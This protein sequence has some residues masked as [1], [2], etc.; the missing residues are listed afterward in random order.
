MAKKRKHEQE[1]D[2]AGE[3]EPEPQKKGKKKKLKE[4]QQE[5]ETLAEI[6]APE[7]PVKKKK[8]SK[9]KLLQEQDVVSCDAGIVKK[10]KKTKEQ[11]VDGDVQQ[12][13]EKKKKRKQSLD[14]QDADQ[15]ETALADDDGAAPDSVQS[16]NDHKVFVGGLPWSVDEATLAEDFKECGD[17]L[18][19]QVLKERETGRSRGIGFVTFKK[20]AGLEAAL[21][22]NGEDYRGRTLKVTKAVAAEN[23]EG[24]SGGKDLSTRLE[25]FVRGLAPTITEDVLW[26]D[27][28]ECGKISKMNMPLDSAGRCKGF[29]WI[30]FKTAESRDKAIKYDGQDYAGKTLRVEKSGLHR[31]S[32]DEASRGGKGAGKGV[33]GLEVFVKNFPYET[34]ET[35]VRKVFSECGE[36]ARLNMPTN[37]KGGHGRC[38]GFAWITFKSEEGVTNA[39]KLTGDNV[40]YIGGRKVFVEK[41]GQH[42]VK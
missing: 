29:A 33:G 39:C 32:N 34:E 7:E 25:V 37:K 27:F 19:T 42:R 35:E 36:I 18:E 11:D 30:T 4:Q 3:E 16:S 12:V 38:M 15:Q 24:T 23:E 8:K 31:S 9:S 28:L 21:Q 41:S 2:E 1:H 10:K 26:R 20:A 5:V 6:E 14:Q 13:T 17:I 22:W 40:A